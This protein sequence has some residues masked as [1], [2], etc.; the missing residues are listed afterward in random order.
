MRRTRF[1]CA[2]GCPAPPLCVLPPEIFIRKQGHEIQPGVLL[3][4][5]I[6]YPQRSARRYS[7][8]YSS[9]SYSHSDNGS[10]NSS[11]CSNCPRR[12]ASVDLISQPAYLGPFAPF[13]GDA[14]RVISDPLKRLRNEARADNRRRN[15]A[16]VLRIP[17]TGAAKRAI[18]PIAP[19]EQLDVSVRPLFV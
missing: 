3:S 14:R 2:T 12:S 6:L 5:A 19:G 15:P 18:V 4:S 9:D 16:R 10:R 1:A 17:R 11:Y 7:Y 8:S 13:H